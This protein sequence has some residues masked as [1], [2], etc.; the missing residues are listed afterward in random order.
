MELPNPDDI[1]AAAA[2][3]TLMW[4]YRP[5]FNTGWLRFNMNNDMFKDKRVR[6]AFALA[7]NKEP[8]VKGLYGGY[9]EVADQLMPPGMWG[10][11]SRAHPYQYDTKRVL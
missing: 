11:P 8:I 6:E 9:G 4:G 2:D 7:I 5:L 10:R 1:K 3:P